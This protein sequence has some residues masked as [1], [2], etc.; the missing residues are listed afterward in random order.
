MKI[1]PGI[2][3]GT[4]CEVRVEDVHLQVRDRPADEHR[5]VAALTG[6]LFVDAAADDG[7]RRAVLVDQ[8]R[9]RRP[10]AP[11]AQRR[12]ISASPPMTTRVDAAPEID[13]IDV[14]DAVEP[15]L[16]HVEV[17]GSQFEQAERIGVAQHIRKIVDVRGLI[18]QPHGATRDERNVQA[19]DREI[20]A[21]RRVDRRTAAGFRTIGL[22]R[23][24]QIV[25]EAAVR[26]HHAFRPGRSI[27]TCR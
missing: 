27:P 23:P 13:V 2:P 18:E 22:R 11:E 4:C 20:E 15:L 8:T 25:A 16:E 17:R 6:G 7:L 9:P 21:E 10:L 14:I 12:A 26:D 3:T 5:S 19:R 1:S 24:V